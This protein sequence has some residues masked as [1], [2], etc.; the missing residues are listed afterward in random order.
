[1]WGTHKSMFPNNIIDLF[2]YGDILL[3]GNYLGYYTITRIYGDEKIIQNLDFNK[4][5]LYLKNLYRFLIKLQDNGLTYRDL[6]IGNAGIDL[7]TLDYIVID[8]DDVTIMNPENL[9]DLTKKTRIHY[10]IGTY[11]PI[12]ILENIKQINI[13]MQYD[14]LYL[15]GLFDIIQYMFKK[16]DFLEKKYISGI[17][18]L[19]EFIKDIERICYPM[20]NLMSCIKNNKTIPE[21]CKAF[22]KSINYMY[23]R[24]NKNDIIN[25]I[26]NIGDF[27]NNSNITNYDL[28]SI[29]IVLLCYIL[30]PLV[31]DNYEEASKYS[32][33]ENYKKIINVLDIILKK[34]ISDNEPEYNPDYENY[35]Q[36]YLKYK[37]KYLKL[38]NSF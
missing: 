6:K 1:M 11:A 29:L 8:Y 9:S 5:M 3:D 15:Y 37:T 34:T 25:K 14:L 36:K 33:Q 31:I 19:F 30:Y 20:Y 7:G 23:E 26:K 27:I 24:S 32:R 2:L 10:S 4:R 13:D 35:R 38:K 21:N 12:Y 16:E 28:D 18:R 17:S 22:I